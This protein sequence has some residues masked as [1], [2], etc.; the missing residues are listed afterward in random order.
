MGD[1]PG[2]SAVLALAGGATYMAVTLERDRIDFP[3][4]VANSWKQQP[5]LDI[6][7]L[8][9]PYVPIFVDV[10]QIV[11]GDQLLGGSGGR[12]HRVPRGLRSNGRAAG[13]TYDA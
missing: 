2:V 1:A 13:G 7:T 11:S 10:G 6:V 4:A 9:H 12:G 3:K 8:R 5:L